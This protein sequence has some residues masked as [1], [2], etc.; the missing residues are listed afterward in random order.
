MGCGSKRAAIAPFAALGWLEISLDIN[1][2][3]EPDLI[4][5]MTDMAHEILLDAFDVAGG[6]IS[7]LERM[8]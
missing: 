3:A 2:G 1:P 7:R 8:L 6:L 5:S 4:G